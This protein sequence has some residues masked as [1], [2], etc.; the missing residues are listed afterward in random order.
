MYHTI[1][2]FK[3][4]TISFIAWEKKCPVIRQLKWECDENVY[5][6]QIVFRGLENKIKL[7]ISLYECPLK[8]LNLGRVW[9]RGI[10]YYDQKCEMR[11]P[12]CKYA[13][14]KAGQPVETSSPV[15]GKGWINGPRILTQMAML[16]NV[17]WSG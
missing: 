11:C 13:S 7:E 15:M 17:L 2:Y 3:E 16:D 6:T 5:A 14:G 9:S 12:R 10:Y 8:Q 4:G 1:F